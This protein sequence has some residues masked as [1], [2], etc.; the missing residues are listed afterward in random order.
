MAQPQMKV[1]DQA[2]MAMGEQPAPGIAA[3]P[4]QNMENMA[5]GGI[6]GYAEGGVSDT[7]EDAFS[8]GGM[9][10]FTQRSEP[11]VRMA[12]GGVPGY[13][14]GKQV[15]DFEALIRSEA[16]RQGVDPDIALRMFMAETGGEKDATKAVSP[17]GATGIGQLMKSA[18]KDMGLSPE[19]RTDPVKNIQASVGYLKRQLDKYGSYD[20]ALAAYNY[21]P[22][23]LDKHLEKNKGA[24]NPIGLPKE[25]ANYLNKILP[26]GSAQA[27]TKAESAVSSEDLAKARV[28]A[29][30]GSELR[31]GGKRYTY[32]GQEIPEAAPRTMGQRVA[33]AG[34]TALSF[35]SAI[36]ATVAGTATSLG[37]AA[38][39]GEAPTEQ[40]FAK[41]VGRFMYSPRTQAGQE[42][43]QAAAEGIASVL[44][45]YIPAATVPSRA[46]AAA[47]SARQAEQAAIEA[48]AAREGVSRA[49]LAPPG[50]ERMTPEQ[51]AAA[52]AKI[53]TPRLPAPGATPEQQAAGIAALEADKAAAA[54]ARR[55]PTE[56]AASEANAARLA[57]QQAADIAAAEGAAGR[58]AGLAEDAATIGAQ[59]ERQA[60]QGAQAEKIA[61]RVGTVGKTGAALGA[62]DKRPIVPETVPSA[63]VPQDLTEKEQE[64][65]IDAAKTAV[66]DPSKAEGWS[67][68]DW[69]TFGFALLANR[70]PYFMEA[71]GMAGLKTLAA[72]QEKAKLTEE[73]ELRQA[74]IGKLKAES[75]Y[76]TET[77]AKSE[78]YNRATRLAQAQIN[79]LKSNPQSY[80]LT[81]EQVEE[82]S[83]AIIRRIYNQL[84]QQE[85]LGGA[86]P[87]APAQG[88]IPSTPPPGA[89]KKIG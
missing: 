5:D 17:A 51:I 22:G 71:V 61:S 88:A 25:T 81:P 50:V 73:K 55:N 19:E 26:I 66:K 43:S 14:A 67:N 82:Q 37:R 34:E 64:K 10:D 49:R 78:L 52:K 79:A 45:A 3:L 41:D 6:V 16:E 20:K 27:E 59:A 58:A 36:P 28:G 75:A 29:I 31:I 70:S 13:A 42:M 2:I 38:I 84:L 77:K 48:A 54:A 30:P 65:V 7:S 35:L 53:E 24:L 47:R 89:V 8:R 62:M 57:R 23:N 32:E 86:A 60:A 44:P 85:G 46:A 80:G 40:Q 9:F 63:V 18:A 68:D 39:R 33:G 76:I 15:R 83:N 21:G 74:Q 87:A 69:L 1:A 11:V 72:K 12:D 56:V 4:A